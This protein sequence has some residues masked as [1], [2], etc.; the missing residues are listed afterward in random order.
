MLAKLIRILRNPTLISERLMAR[1]AAAFYAQRT[2]AENDAERLAV[3]GDVS[4]FVAEARATPTYQRLAAEASD[5][6]RQTAMSQT[7]SLADCVTMYC[8]IRQFKP[9]VMVETGVFYG[10]LSAMILHAMAAN[11]GGSLYSID[12][13]VESDGL[14]ADQRGA[15]V[16][17]DL[18]HMWRLILGDSR[19]ELPKL[20]KKLRQI[21]AFNHDSLHTTEHMLWEYETA[22]PYLRIGGVISSH[23]VLTTPAWGRFGRRY[24][25]GIG[26]YGRVYRLGMAVKTADIRPPKP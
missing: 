6:A 4:A 14:P 13:P 7:T 18:R 8:L 12:L 9:K 22:W 25:K 10:G 16:P 3:L 17:E 1:Q 5:P 11:G 24:R 21:D 15:L 2:E 20:L 26:Q 23:D 19:E